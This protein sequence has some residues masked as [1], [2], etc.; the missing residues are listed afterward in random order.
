MKIATSITL[1]MHAEYNGGPDFIQLDIDCLELNLYMYLY[2]GVRMP[3]P[4]FH[5]KCASRARCKCE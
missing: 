5:R 1:A 4:S 2:D 3:F